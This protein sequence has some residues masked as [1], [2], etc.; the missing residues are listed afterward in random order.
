MEACW[1]DWIALGSIGKAPAGVGATGH[2]VVWM[3]WGEK[4]WRG[5]EMGRRRDE[6]EIIFGLQ[7][8]DWKD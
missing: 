5:E 7:G 6:G 8:V 4:Q 2:G 1:E 3:G